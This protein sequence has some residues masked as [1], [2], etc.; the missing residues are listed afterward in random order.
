MAPFEVMISES[1]E[2]MLAVTAPE[3]VAAV[4]EV[5][6]RWGLPSAVVGLVTD[7]GDVTVV[8]GD[9][10]IAR[11]P[12]R[13]LAS[14][15]IEMKRLAVAAATAPRRACAGRRAHLPTTGCPSAAWIPERCSR[16]SSA[17]RT[18]AAA[19]GSRPSTT[20]RSARTRSKA[21]TTPPASCASRAPARRW[22]LAT[23]SQ[24]QVA[25]HDPALAAALAVAESTRNVAITGA[26]PLGVTNCLNFGDPGNPEAY[27]QLAESVRGMGDAC[28]A[29]GV[30]ITG[31]NVSLYNESPLG[32]IAPTAQIGVAGLVGR[33]RSPDQPG[34]QAT[35]AISWCCSAR[36]VPAWPA[37][38]TNG[39]PVRRLRIGRRRSTWRARRR[40]RSCSS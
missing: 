37:R 31:G 12:A 29:L 2:R 19:P 15:S 10:E 22:S 20:R 35:R 13:A 5:C 3:N 21:A 27:W 4:Q 25:L 18:W 28:R 26:R 1:Q 39:W 6:R 16:R 40:S 30:P 32:R 23:D 7:D 38:P 11:V 9:S 8:D 33:H 34:V 36:L 17:T 14:Q 24:P